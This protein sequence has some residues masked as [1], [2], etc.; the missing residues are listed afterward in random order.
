MPPK[1]PSLRRHSLPQLPRLA[2]QLLLGLLPIVVWANGPDQRPNILLCISDDQSWAHV[3]AMGDPVVQTPAF[4]RV[5]KEGLLFTHA[6]CDA[7]SC[8][9]S[10]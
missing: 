7:P 10:R 2:M 6:F 5:A 4:D 9:P 3:G 1:P 8:A